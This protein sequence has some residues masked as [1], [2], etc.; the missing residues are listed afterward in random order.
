MNKQSSK[1]C[2]TCIYVVKRTKR[3]GGVDPLEGENRRREP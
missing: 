2:M 3:G 1:P